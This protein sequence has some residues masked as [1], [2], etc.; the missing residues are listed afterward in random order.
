MNDSKYVYKI[1]DSRTRETLISRV[2]ARSHTDAEKVA[3]D[4]LPSDTRFVASLLQPDI[5]PA[6]K[7]KKRTR[8]R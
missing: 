7:K 4:L 1:I 6:P 8:K 5:K 2:C 3:K